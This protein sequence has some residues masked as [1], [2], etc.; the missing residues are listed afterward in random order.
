M[1]TE[2]ERKFYKRKRDNG[3]SLKEL[4]ERKVVIIL[5]GIPGTGKTTT[6][7][8]LT[9]LFRDKG[10]NVKTLSRD[11]IREK[12]C[13]KT[14]QKYVSSFSDATT[15]TIV[16]D[17]YYR[18]LRKKAKEILW[19]GGNGAV[20]IIDS[21]NTK[22]PDL[23]NTFKILKEFNPLEGIRETFDIIVYTKRKEHGSVHQIPTDTM[24]KFRKELSESDA[25]LT[26][27]QNRRSA[28]KIK[29]SL[30]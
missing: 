24:E 3:T 7:K 17:K 27:Y 22:I 18:S 28:K 26:D 23:I 8:K 9:K 13:E 12:Y 30:K 4:R 15:N 21:T 6:R 5:R 16:R 20:F 10:R 14:K 29:S 1:I 25:W 2:I 11:R 19:Y